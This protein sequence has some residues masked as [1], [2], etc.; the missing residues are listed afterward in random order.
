MADFGE[1]RYGLSKRGGR[2]IIWNSHVNELLHCEELQTS[3][4]GDP[5]L[6]MVDA[7]WNILVIAS[8]HDLALLHASDHWI[9]DGNFD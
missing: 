4:D 8:D 7:E 3:V 2:V 9:A 5:R 6:L 1:P